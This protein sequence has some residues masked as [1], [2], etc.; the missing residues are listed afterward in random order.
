ME[1]ACVLKRC[2]AF[3]GH[4]SSSLHVAA[5]V[6]TPTVALFGPTDPRR[7]LPSSFAGTVIQK[8]VFC[9]PCYSARCRTITH[10]CMRRIEV[11]EVLTAAL[12][13]LADVERQVR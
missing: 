8:D 2:D 10:A 5:A 13:L 9:S 7:H 1:L 11:E 6:G 12:A 3:L 4:D